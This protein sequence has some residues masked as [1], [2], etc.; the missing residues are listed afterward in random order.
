MLTAVVSDIHANADALRSVLDDLDRAGAKRIVCLGDNVGYGAEP[1]ECLD[2]LVES[3]ATILAGN[4]DLAVSGELSVARFTTAARAAVIYAR[5]RI[6]RSQ[7]PILAGMPDRHETHGALFVHA[8]PSDPKR[9]P[10]VRDSEAARPEFAGARFTIAFYGHT[11]LPVTFVEDAGHV[12]M[13]MNPVIG[14]LPGRRYL[15]N[16]GS[17]GQPRDQDPRAAYVLFDPDEGKISLRRVDYDVESAAA[18]MR[19]AGLPDQ[20]GSRL[21]LG[22]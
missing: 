3:E 6:R 18:R 17:V 1:E 19:T 5:D 21:L 13:T 7:R 14:I 2:L 12:S 20:L 9:F 11:H 10:Y 22:V 8:S 4:H 16:V 15:V